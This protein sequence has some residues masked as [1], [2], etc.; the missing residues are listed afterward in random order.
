MFIANIGQR[1]RAITACCQRE[2]N[3][4]LA[5]LQIR[6]FRNCAFY[7]PEAAAAVVSGIFVSS[8]LALLPFTSHVV[9]SHSR[10]IRERLDV[11]G[12]LRRWNYSRCR[13]VT[14][15]KG[16]YGLSQCGYSVITL[17]RRVIHSNYTFLWDETFLFAWSDGNFM[18]YVNDKKITFSKLF[19]I[20]KRKV[21]K[22]MQ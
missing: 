19:K 9:F 13:L 4:S 15:W 2:W 5:C 14:H 3:K 12:P 17:T 10:W 18:V 20:V 8:R 21:R 11:T 1:V 7:R 22:L 6:F 16:Q